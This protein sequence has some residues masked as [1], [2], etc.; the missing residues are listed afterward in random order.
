MVHGLL[1]LLFRKEPDDQDM[2]HEEAAMGDSRCEE[3]SSTFDRL[4]PHLWVEVGAS[5][6]ATMSNRCYCSFVTFCFI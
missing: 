6:E 2:G 4:R 1:L 5:R 3:A